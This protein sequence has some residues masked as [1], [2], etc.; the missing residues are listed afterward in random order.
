M[1]CYSILSLSCH[2]ALLSNECENE[3]FTLA[4]SVRRGADH[5]FPS[6]DRLSTEFVASMEKATGFAHVDCG[7]SGFR[8]E[9][10]E[11]AI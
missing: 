4:V 11:W 8:M 3:F 1:R 5:A 9:M 10:G 2:S 6:S 7:A